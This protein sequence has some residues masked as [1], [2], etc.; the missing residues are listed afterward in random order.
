MIYRVL[1]PLFKNR[2]S[3]S[4]IA[5]LGWIVFFDPY[6]LMERTASL[7][8]VHRLENE[9]IFYR[10][11]IKDDNAKLD[12]LMSNPTNLEKF[13]REQY[14]MRKDNEDIFVVE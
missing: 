13:A 11:K 8:H 7:K 10:E 5:F 4:L 9:I 12:E 2:Y 3:L 1:L 14:F 6:S